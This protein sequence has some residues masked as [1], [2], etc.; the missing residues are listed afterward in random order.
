MFLCLDVTP[1]TLRQALDCGA[2]L[3]LSH[4]PVIFRP[5]KEISYHSVQAQLLRCGMQVLCA[6]TNLDK[7]PGGVNDSLCAQLCLP[8][9]KMPPT[10]AD[11]FLNVCTAEEAMT[12]EAFAAL[13]KEK[14]GATVSW[15]ERG[16]AVSKIGV[17]SGAG[18]DFLREAAALDCDAYLTGEA[19]HHDY[20]DAAALGLSLFTVGHYETEI[21]ITEALEQLLRKKFPALEVHRVRETHPLLRTI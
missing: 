10:V 7:A 2:D 20:L 19:S 9:E 15:L 3:M 14:L 1:E 12:E 11:G 13:V 16:G 21:M 18:A 5:L 8:F 17:C 6:H 4:H